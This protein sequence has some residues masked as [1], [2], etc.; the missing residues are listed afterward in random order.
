M[1]FIFL[2]E[3][4]SPKS[5]QPK[6]EEVTAIERRFTERFYSKDKEEHEIHRTGISGQISRAILFQGS[7]DSEKIFAAGQE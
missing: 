3:S 7:C 2:I 1:K 6:T 4:I 5:L